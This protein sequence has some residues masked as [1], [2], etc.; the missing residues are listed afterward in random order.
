MTPEKCS[1]FA[2]EFVFSHVA[3]QAVVYFLFR[4]NTLIYIGQSTGLMGR[5]HSHSVNKED[6]LFN[7]GHRFDRVFFVAV[8]DTDD[9]ADVEGAF[10]RHFRPIE[11]SG[12]PKDRGR[13]QEILE[14][15]KGEL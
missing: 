14:R 2:T 9:L 1:A 13:D 11:N 10:I 12:W 8:R 7:R 6:A 15:Y 5:L 4:E 3:K